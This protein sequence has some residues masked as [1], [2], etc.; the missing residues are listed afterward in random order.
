M[1]KE[2]EGLPC[3][4]HKLTTTMSLRTSLRRRP[5]LSQLF[6]PRTFRSIFSVFARPFTSPP[7]P[8]S[9]PPSSSSHAAPPLSRRLR[10]AVGLSGGVDSSVAAWLLKREGHEVI[11]VHMSNWDESD[12]TGESTERSQ[13]TSAREEWE[14]VQRLGRQLGIEVQQAGF[15]REYWTEVFE[16]FLEGYSAGRTPNPD[17]LCNREIKFKRFLKFAVDR[18]GADV[19]ATG[20]YARMKRE[21]EVL[22]PNKQEGKTNV[23]RKINQRVTGGLCSGII[24]Q[25]STISSASSPSSDGSVTELWCGVDVIKDQSYFLSAVPSFALSRAV[26]PLGGLQ[27]TQV[28]LSS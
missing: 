7:P 5:R 23:V 21:G 9:S 24:L 2:E 4:Y 25:E 22:S 11:G 17:I 13:C 26:F 28:C 8:A 15:T 18:L 3:R 20:H 1:R 19:V 6:R 12:E 27:K 16:P 14:V 10:V